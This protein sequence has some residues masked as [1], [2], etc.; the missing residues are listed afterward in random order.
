MKT[1]LPYTATLILTTG[2]SL[3]TFA[4]SEEGPPSSSGAIAPVP[5]AARTYIPSILEVLPFT[6]PAPPVEKKVPAMRIDSAI[7]VPAGNFRTLTIIRGEASTLPDI[8]IPP[9]PVVQERRELTPEELA[10]IAYQRRHNLLIG[11][12]IIDHR[13][14]AVHWRHPD[15]GESYEAV[16]GF[17]IGLLAG[18]GQFVRDGETYS[19][20]LMHS[21]YATDRS[22]NFAARMFPDLPEVATDAITFIKGNSKDPVGTAPIT[23]LKELI[24][25]EKGRL[26]TYQESRTRYQEAS[27]AWEK[28]HPVPARDETFW[29][30]PHRGS[31]YLADP[32]PEAARR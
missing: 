20:M 17:D 9:E 30:R 27:A 26:T 14:S 23:L 16:C 13:L 25:S 29:F 10:A 32:K 21:N 11:A 2:C 7:T 12:T 6:P 24:T 31:R 5:P 8:P 28:S 3:M 22:R 1:R 19:L 4:F 15:T 18:I